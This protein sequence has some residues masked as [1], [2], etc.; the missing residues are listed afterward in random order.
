M[1]IAVERIP[2]PNIKTANSLSLRIYNLS[3]RVSKSE[4][5]FRNIF[6]LGYN[7]P[8]RIV[9]DYIFDS[10][11]YNTTSYVV[12]F[13]STFSFKSFDT[14]CRQFFFKHSILVTNSL[15]NQNLSSEDTSNDP[16]LLRNQTCNV[17]KLI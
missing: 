5:T 2:N 12:N 1:F 17:C 7:N 14:S 16:Y 11:P 13:V 6:G 4:P 15:R 8:S 3:V 9:Y 10:R